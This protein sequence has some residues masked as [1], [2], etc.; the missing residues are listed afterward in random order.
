MILKGLEETEKFGKEFAG[1][2]TPG[3]VV[4]LTGP[5][6]AGKTTLAEA[7]LYS[8]G[9][10]KTPGRV[11]KGNAFLDTFELEK[12]R[13]I[14]IFSKQ[15]V[16]EYNNVTY[17]LLDTPGHA[18]FASEAER[19][20]SVLDYAVLV[21]SGTDGV[22]SHT[23]TLFHLLEEYKVPVIVF[24]NK[25][26]IAERSEQSLL[27]E[28]GDRTGYAFGNFS[29]PSEEDIASLSEAL[30]EEYLS[31]GKMSPETIKKEVRAR[32]IIPVFFGSALKLTGVEQFLD[33]LSYLT[34]PF[35][36]DPSAPVTAR[37]IKITHYPDGTRLTHLKLLS[38]TVS[39]RD[40]L[41]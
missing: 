38:G 6:G 33:G 15:A 3:S 12:K 19:T 17:T 41:N 4:A 35:D 21:I 22:Q 27:D 14:T 23:V 25:M 40:T 39:V 29:T 32:H 18:D 36:G 9:I 2:L 8:C 20:L 34:V 5:L 31:D 16:F 7:L 10:V 30:M 37:V 11:D 28:L 24:V 26:D 1:T 13:G